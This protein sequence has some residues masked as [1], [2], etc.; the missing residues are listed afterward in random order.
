MEEIGVYNIRSC[1]HINEYDGITI[2]NR[3]YIGPIH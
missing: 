1:F 2:K 3:P